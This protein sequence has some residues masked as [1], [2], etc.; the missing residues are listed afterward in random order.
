MQA[1]VEGGKPYA[2]KD[3]IN[4]GLRVARPNSEGRSLELKREFQSRQMTG[5]SLMRETE[6]GL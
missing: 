4:R 1:T 3:Q 5:I 6:P 2:L